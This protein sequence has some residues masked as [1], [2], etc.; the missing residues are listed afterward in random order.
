MNTL[1]VSASVLKI[2]VGVVF[3]ISAVAKYITIDAFEMYV[4][5]F[6]LF[7][8]VLSFYLAR[9]VIAAELILA[10]SLISHRNHRF[11]LIASIL[12]LVCFVV[13]LTYAHLVGRT[14]NCHCFGDLVPFS[15]VQ[16]IMKN[17][18]LII[19]LLFVY[20]YASQEWY[21]RWWLVA[22][23]YIA[24]GAVMYLYMTKVLHVLDMLSMVLMLVMLCV[25]VLASLPFYGRWYVT[26]A[27]VL[28][29]VVTVFILTPPDSW[30]YRNSDERYDEELFRQQLMPSDYDSVSE[31]DTVAVSVLAGRGLDKGRQIVAFFSPKCGYCQLAAE[32]ICTIAGRY[33][34]DTSR[35]TYVFPIV[36]DT[37]AYAGFYEHSRS[38]HYKEVRIDKTLF[39][40]IT[41]A[42]F[43]IVLLLEDGQAVA[44]YA[45]RNIDEKMVREFLQPVDTE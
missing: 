27:L 38:P 9:L 28:T 5:S 14:D 22:L 8:M 43:P 7:P 4:Y 26:A 36:K 3:I 10:A 21:P 37:A 35:I 13:F 15:P 41:R 40:R 16:S 24:T 33:D 31:D 17:A 25:G 2:I 12:F 19:L 42:S 20:K 29:P 23:I 39:I 30:F 6:G 34:L 1:R 44:S 11:T 18:V 32:K 45:Y